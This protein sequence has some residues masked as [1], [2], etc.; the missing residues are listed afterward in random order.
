MDVTITSQSLNAFQAMRF[1][2]RYAIGNLS[3][4]ETPAEVPDRLQLS[5]D[6]YSSTEQSF[7]SSVDNYLNLSHRDSAALF[8]DFTAPD[9]EN[10]TAML[11][12]ISNLIKRGI[13]GF[14]YLDL[15]D[16]PY[17][18]YASTG[19]VKPASDLKIYR[20]NLNTSS[21]FDNLI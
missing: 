16:R 19:M 10:K 8:D 17:K 7:I 15:N 12:T 14:E 6:K 4:N 18:S 11:K 1:V 13:V 2:S 20:K 9:S 5:Q 3:E 21:H